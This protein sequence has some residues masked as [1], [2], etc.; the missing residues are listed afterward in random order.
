MKAFLH[1]PLAAITALFIYVFG[2]ML[3]VMFA[4]TILKAIVKVLAQLMGLL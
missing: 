4:Y 1:D 3:A 2:S